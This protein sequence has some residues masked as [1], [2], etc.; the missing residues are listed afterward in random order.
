MG[1]KIGNYQSAQETTGQELPHVY[2]ILVN[3]LWS[4]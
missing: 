4:L 2:V 3:Q 1:F